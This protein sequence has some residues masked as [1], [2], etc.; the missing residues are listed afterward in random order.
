MPPLP[1]H[2]PA[3]AGVLLVLDAIGRVPPE[4]IPLL[5]SPAPQP[6]LKVPI[7]PAA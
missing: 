4:S 1:D 7:L 3:S 2:A 6:P 5:P